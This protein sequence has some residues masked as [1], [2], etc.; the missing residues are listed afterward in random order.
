MGSS[1][2]PMGAVV[3]SA[4]HQPVRHLTARGDANG[5]DAGL[6]L[7]RRQRRW[8]RSGCPLVPARLRNDSQLSYP[9][10]AGR[11]GR[12]HWSSRLYDP[13]GICALPGGR[14][15]NWLPSA[16]YEACSLASHPRTYRGTTGN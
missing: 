3:R 15:S 12:L 9:T 4:H 6:A 14:A 16:G 1:T 10:Q 5:R 8:E 11:A 7:G 2:D 13:L